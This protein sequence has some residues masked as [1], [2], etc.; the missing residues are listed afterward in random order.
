MQHND[1]GGRPIRALEY[2]VT[3]IRTTLDN[4]LKTMVQE[5]KAKL[6][7]VP[8]NASLYSSTARPPC[9]EDQLGLPEHPSSTQSS[10][11]TTTHPRRDMRSY[12]A[13]IARPTEMKGSLF[14]L[15]RHERRLAVGSIFHTPDIVGSD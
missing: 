4:S 10:D 1:D 5:Q 2:T 14:V 15:P 8:I 11:E 6:T 13:S 12:I 7:I 3:E 9:A